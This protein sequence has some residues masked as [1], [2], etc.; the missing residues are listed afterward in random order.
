LTLP[1]VADYEIKVPAIP[2]S[3]TNGTPWWLT[4]TC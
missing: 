2:L 3:F 1:V 4:L